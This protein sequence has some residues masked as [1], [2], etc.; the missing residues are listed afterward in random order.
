MV[1]FD[2]FEVVALG[3]LIVVSIDVHR[4]IATDGD[5]L[6]ALYFKSLVH[7]N[8][9]GLIRINLVGL[10]LYY[11]VRIGSCNKTGVVV[12]DAGLPVMPDST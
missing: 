3:L 6:V 2:R 12:P 5:R 1:S 10:T 4:T 9:C 7:L 8:F 11:N